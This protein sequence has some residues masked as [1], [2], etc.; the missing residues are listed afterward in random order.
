MLGNN[1]NFVSSHGTYMFDH[2]IRTTFTHTTR[3]VSRFFPWLFIESKFMR[4][5]KAFHRNE[6]LA[7]RRTTTHLHFAYFSRIMPSTSCS[8][9]TC[10]D[11]HFRRSKN[12]LNSSHLYKRNGVIFATVL[13]PFFPL[14]E[15]S[16]MKFKKKS[17]FFLHIFR[18]YS[19]KNTSLGPYT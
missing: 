16:S 18:G 12:I 2:N 13:H 15:Y 7:E 1:W 14:R 5:K 19:F 17:I 9:Y 10:M 3:L 11:I 6:I 8:S 4:T